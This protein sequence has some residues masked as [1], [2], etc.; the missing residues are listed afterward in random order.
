MTRLDAAVRRIRSAYLKPMPW[1]LAQQRIGGD[2][3][4]QA[5]HGDCLAATITTRRTQR[6]PRAR[7]F[8]ARARLHVALSGIGHRS[9]IARAPP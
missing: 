7:T 6:C 5:P 3:A 4:R 9:P 8:A 2:H 1:T